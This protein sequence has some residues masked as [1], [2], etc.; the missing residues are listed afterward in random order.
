MQ[1]SYSMNFHLKCHHKTKNEVTL[2]RKKKTGCLWDADFSVQS[3]LYYNLPNESSWNFICHVLMNNGINSLY[4]MKVSTDESK[5]K[6]KS[7]LFSRANNKTFIEVWRGGWVTSTFNMLKGR[8]TMEN[9]TSKKL[10][11]EKLVQ[12]TINTDILFL[13]FAYVVSNDFF[14]SNE[15]NISYGFHFKT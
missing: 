14:F 1:V 7:S 12:E 6:K 13:R 5:L 3:N 2:Y 8:L 9:K 4:N 11:T 15:N 10:F